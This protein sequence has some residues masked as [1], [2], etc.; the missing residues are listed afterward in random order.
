MINRLINTLFFQL[1]PLCAC[2]WQECKCF[3]E[4]IRGEQ[5]S[6]G[7]VPLRQAAG[8]DTPP[9]VTGLAS[10]AAPHSVRWLHVRRMTIVRRPGKQRSVSYMS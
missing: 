4:G 6:Q 10:P 8:R 9:A 3:K 7:L 2:D 1:S 5:I